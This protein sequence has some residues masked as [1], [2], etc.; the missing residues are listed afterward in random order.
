MKKLAFAI[1]LALSLG[2]HAQDDDDDAAQNATAQTPTLNKEQRAAV[3]LVVAQAVAAKPAERVA[4]Y[5]QV[6]DPGALIAELGD[7]EANRA[8]ERAASAEVARLQGLYKAGA[9][10]SLRNLESAQAEQAKAHAQAET[11]ATRFA[12]RWSPLAA[13]NAKRPKLVDALA[14]GRSALVRVDLPGQQSVGTVPESA[15]VDI[16]GIEIRGDVLGALTQASDAQSASL[17]VAIADAPKGLAVGTRVAVS[18]LGAAKAGFLVPRGAI[19]YEEGGAFVYHELASKPGDEKT[20][21]ARKS[22]T[23]LMPSGDGWLIGGLDDDD[24]IV[25]HGAGVLWSLEGVGDMPADD[26]D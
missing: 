9:S 16:D 17:L 18:L 11:A 25:V 5:G 21:Y 26:D 8:A 14:S 24:R 10:A 15:V 2:A 19:L 20:S 6:L 12:L 7:V 4:A 1:C 3:G 23:L 22:V 13:A